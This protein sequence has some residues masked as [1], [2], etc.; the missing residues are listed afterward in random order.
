MRAARP[1]W[2]ECFIQIA[3]LTSQRATCG[4]AHVGCVL[5]KDCRILATG[6]NGAPPGQAHCSEGGCLMVDGHCQ[7]AT[8]SEIAVLANAARYGCS[9]D[10][11]QLWLTHFPCFGCYKALLNAGVA[12]VTY[13]TL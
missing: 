4:R 2:A 8:H 11:T 9:T 12:K 1:T 6:Y 7:R 13:R 3:E 10:G 5:T